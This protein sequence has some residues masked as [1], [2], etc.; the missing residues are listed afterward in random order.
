MTAYLE[1]YHSS[2]Y[3]GYDNVSGLDGEDFRV[4][5]VSNGVLRVVDGKADMGVRC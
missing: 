2:R 3:P 4:R 1:I 5:D